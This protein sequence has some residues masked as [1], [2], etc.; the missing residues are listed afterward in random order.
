MYFTGFLPIS[1]TSPQVHSPLDVLG[2]KEETGTERKGFYHPLYNIAHITISFHVTEHQQEDAVGKVRP[3][4]LRLAAALRE[5]CRSE[6]TGARW[7]CSLGLR[8]LKLVWR[9]FDIMDGSN[10]C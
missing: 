6:A 9:Q 10:P 1:S 7:G 3:G 4:L 8:M 5:Q 2:L